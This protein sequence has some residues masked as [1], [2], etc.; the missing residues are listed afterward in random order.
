[1]S[2]TIHIVLFLL[3]CSCS[4]GNNE[5]IPVFISDENVGKTLNLEKTAQKINKNWFEIFNDKDL[6][7]L[8]NQLWK[9]NFSIA[10]GKERLQQARYN[11]YIYSKQNYPFIDSDNSYNFNKNNNINDISSDINTFKLGFD[12]SW[13][14]DIW[15]KGKYI[16]DQYYELMKGAKYS[17]ENI[18]SS[19]VAEMTM[20]YINLRKLQ[21]KMQIA[22]KNIKL[23]QD[24]LEIVKSKYQT[25]TTDKLALEQA[26][27]TLEKTKSTIPLLNTQIENYKNS[28]AV[29]LGVLPQD[30]P[31][32]LEECKKNITSTPFKYSVK[33]LYNLPLNIIRTRPD[34]MASE[35]KIITQNMVVN[36]A[37][38]DLYPSF[39]IGA[40]FGFISS[41]GNTL[42]KTNNQTYGYTPSINIPIWHWGQLTNNIE[43]QKHIKEEFILNYN[44]ALLTALMEVKNA[45]TSIEQSYKTNSSLSSSL[46]NIKNIMQ[47][48]K[49]KYQNGLIEFTDVALAEQNYLEAE[50][51][52]IDSNAEILQNITAFYKATGGGYNIN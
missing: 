20:N 32:N 31:I 29:L 21:K 27:F 36:Q 38:A 26:L 33:K 24:I 16:S 43:L 40:T 49:D 13:E 47:L 10:I 41:S 11:L 19:I 2:K 34:I 42:I 35:Q 50:N 48:T 46:H 25:G 52:F 3:L 23:Q 4:V 22:Q 51:N 15:G 14:L 18:K 44:E 6:N 8:L 45:I 5:V 30:L 39:N 12:M 9:S 37:I 7:T 28:I 1:M 17:L